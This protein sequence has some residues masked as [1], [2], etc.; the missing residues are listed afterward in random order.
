[1]V[2][3]LPLAAPVILPAGET[4]FVQLY[5][6]PPTLLLNTTDVDVPEQMV[7]GDGVATA[8]G[9]GFTVITAFT[10][11]PVQPPAI[12]ETLYVAVPGFEPVA[13]RTCAIDAPDDAEAPDTPD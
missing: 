5:E 13:E 10:G 9:E 7:C 2:L 8:T 11:V 3:P 12:A 6:V 4:T 1:M